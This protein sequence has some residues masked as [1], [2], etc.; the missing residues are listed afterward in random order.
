[1]TRDGKI[2]QLIYISTSRAETIDEAL[3]APILATSERYNAVHEITGLLLAGGNRFL[4]ALEG[5]VDAVKE[6][7]AGIRADP[8]HFALIELST[9]E[10]A[11]REFGTWSMA[12]TQGGDVDEGVE[13]SRA[14]VQLTRTLR[15]PDVRVLFTDLRQSAGGGLSAIWSNH[16]VPRRRP[17]SRLPWP[18]SWTPACTRELN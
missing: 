5:P 18:R 1:M 13:T 4:Q 14:V 7:F 9:R 10:V 6:V 11:A 17:G 3:I 12:Y 2:L 8:R 16:S 15:D